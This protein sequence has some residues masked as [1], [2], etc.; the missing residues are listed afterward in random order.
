VKTDVRLHYV[1]YNLQYQ[2]FI[3]TD[4]AVPG[5]KR[6]QAY[7]LPFLLPE[8]EVMQRFR[9]LV[10]PMFMQ[11]GNLRLR[12]SNLRRTRDLLLPR[13]ISGALDVTGL[14]IAVGD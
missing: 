14:E 6:N 9:D 1:Y 5:L 8:A 10:E 3:S 13:L 11:I 4:T 7:L 12:S 2:N